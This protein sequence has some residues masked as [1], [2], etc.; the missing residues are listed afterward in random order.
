MALGGT[1]LTFSSLSTW[2]C[3]NIFWM[4]VLRHR[5]DCLERL[6][7]QGGLKELLPPP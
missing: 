3:K 6:N 7:A 1:R 4:Q 2:L 5:T